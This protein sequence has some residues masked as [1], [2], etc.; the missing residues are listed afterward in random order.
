[1]GEASSGSNHDYRFGRVLVAGRPSGWAA[2]LQEGLLSVGFKVLECGP[3]DRA[4]FERLLPDLVVVICDSVEP[5]TLAFC[6]W[7]RARSSI[8]LVVV[9]C[10]PERE[11]LVVAI[12]SGADMV[13]GAPIRQREV[14]ARVRAL[15]RR[16]PARHADLPAVVTYGDLR[17]DRNRRRLELPGG[18]LDLAETEFKL[19]ESLLLAAPK[20]AARSEL[21]RALAVGGAGLDGLMRQLRARLEAIESWR[22]IV[23]VRSVGF[24]IL[25]AHPGVPASSVAPP[26]VI[27]LPLLALE[28]ADQ[29]A[30]MPR[31]LPEGS[32]GSD[33]LVLT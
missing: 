15:L 6:R 27:D 24:R 31:G 11:D 1:M 17:L 28:E 22:R 20:V 19:M 14:E 13:L 18:T 12:D 32:A 4:A 23:A 10:R 2:S 21:Q 16:R 33:G 8:P 9:V 5:G 7:I 26:A 3:E 29:A 30:N 25:S